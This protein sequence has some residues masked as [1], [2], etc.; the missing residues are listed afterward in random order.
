MIRSD[1]ATALRFLRRPVRLQP[2]GLQSGEVQALLRAAGQTGHGQARRNYT[3][4][5]LLLETG[6]QVGEAARLVIADCEIRPRSGRV[7]VRAGKGRK[8]RE[9]PLNASARWALSLYLKAQPDITLHDPLF[10]SE[11]GGRAMSLRT[12]QATIQ[13]LAC[14]AKITHLPASCHTRRHTFASRLSAGGVSDHFVTL[15]LRQCDADVF[16]R[17]S[18]AK[19][20]RMREASSKLDRQANEHS[21]SFVTTKPN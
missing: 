19:L 3:R 13:K 14:R 15:M 1:P 20:N 21:K 7:W 18:Q 9:V 12:I 4:L 5:Q 2:K 10:L 17:Y 16:K 8:V 6:L 11:R